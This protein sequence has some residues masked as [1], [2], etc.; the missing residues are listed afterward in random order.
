MFDW[1]EYWKLLALL[2]A[3]VHP[4][5]ALP[6]FLSLTEDRPA[7][8]RHVGFVTSVAVGVILIVSVFVGQEL[9]DA[10]GITIPS[11][12][13]AGGLLILFTALTMI[14][15]PERGTRE[16]PTDKSDST[17]RDS[18][19]VVPLA[20]PILAGPGAISTVIVYAH[21]GTALHHDLLICAVIIAVAASVF[22]LFRL[23][24]PIA[25]L[26]GHTGMRILTQIMGLIIAAV[27]VEFITQG[28]AAIFPGLQAQ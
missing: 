8:R 16:T 22:V 21:K 12:R 28:L 3:L 24:P 2:W 6:I 13:I 23:A 26:I 27:A 19:A 20:I 5:G 7:E 15:V 10:F 11:F 17:A 25:S 9:L 1:Q 4:I 18:V 14:H